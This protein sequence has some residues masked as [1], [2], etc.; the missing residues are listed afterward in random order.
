MV[1]TAY[2]RSRC[3]TFRAG[4]RPIDKPD[5]DDKWIT[6]PAEVGASEGR[7][8]HDFMMLNPVRSSAT[9]EQAIHTLRKVLKT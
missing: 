7:I 3:R 2:G 1:G 5:V 6:A 9:V 4:D 8:L